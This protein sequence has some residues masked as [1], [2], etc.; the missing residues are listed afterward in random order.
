MGFAVQE[1]LG[2]AADRPLRA[3]QR[4]GQERPVRAG[5]FRRTGGV[6]HQ[7]AGLGDPVGE[8][9]GGP[10][11]LAHPGVQPFERPGV[12]RGGQLSGGHGFVVGPEGDHV[13]AADEDLR[14]QQGGDRAAELSQPCG[15]VHF[16]L[17]GLVRGRR[18]PGEYV[19]GP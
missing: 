11:D 12:L 13:I 5:Q 8:V 10:V 17:G 2:P 6:G 1:L 3:V 14:R 18:H 9:R 7:R 19:A 4:A 16:E 15:D